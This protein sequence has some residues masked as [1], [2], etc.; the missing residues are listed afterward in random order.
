MIFVTVGTQL[1]F[2]RLLDA[3]NEIAPRLGEE[4]VA[5]TAEPGRDWPALDCHAQLDPAAFAAQFARARVIVAHVGIG[6]ILSARR[7][8]KPLVAMPRR[9]DLGEHRNDHQSATAQSLDGM[10]GLHVVRD[11]RELEARLARPD[12]APA[13]EGDGPLR[14]ALIDRLRGFL[15]EA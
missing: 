9:F 6:T 7:W 4:V 13:S 11:A 8:R 1:P 10:P 5:Q 14:R 15:G 12:L 2:P 3:M